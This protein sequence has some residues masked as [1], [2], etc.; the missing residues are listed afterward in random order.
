MRKSDSLKGYLKEVP[1]KRKHPINDTEPNFDAHKSK[2]KL[3]PAFFTKIDTSKLKARAEEMII[4]PFFANI[5][6]SFPGDSSVCF[7]CMG[8]FMKINIINECRHSIC[9][10]CLQKKQAK[11]SDILC[12]DQFCGYLVDQKLHGIK[13]KKNTVH[14][15]NF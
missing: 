15:V 4:E 1:Q 2:G 9:D 13:W 12:D 6:D 10:D 5:G 3:S 8:S 7:L 14:K 11:S